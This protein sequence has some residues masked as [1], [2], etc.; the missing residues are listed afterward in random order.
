MDCLCE[1]TMPFSSKRE[2]HCSY[3]T[4]RLSLDRSITVVLRGAKGNDPTVISGLG[5][6]T[7]WTGRNPLARNCNR[8]PKCNSELRPTCQ[9]WLIVSPTNQVEWSW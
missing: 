4:F 3:L 6:N 5:L 8:T 2:G 7:E 9:T 1:R